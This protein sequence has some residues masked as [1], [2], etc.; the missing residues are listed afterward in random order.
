MW[1]WPSVEVWSHVWNNVVE[2]WKNKTLG[3]QRRSSHAQ[4]AEGPSSPST[5]VGGGGRQSSLTLITDQSS[6]AG[7]LTSPSAGYSPSSGD[8]RLRYVNVL[9]RQVPDFPGSLQ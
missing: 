3:G 1:L 2:S 4:Y 8:S 9:P 6:G 5:P 7:G